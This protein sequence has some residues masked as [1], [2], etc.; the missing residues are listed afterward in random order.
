M[1]KGVLSE[2]HIAVLGLTALLA[3]CG[4]GGGG[5]TT[6]AL[7]TADCVSGVVQTSTGT[8]LP[9][10]YVTATNPQTG[11]ACAISSVPTAGDGSYVISLS[12]C[13]AGQSPVVLTAPGGVTTVVPGGSGAT[14]AGTAGSASPGASNPVP[15]GGS[16]GSSSGTSV[17][18]QTPSGT[19]S[20]AGTSSPAGTGANPG[21]PAPGTSSAGTTSSGAGTGGATGASGTSGATGSAGSD[22]GLLVNSW[23]PGQGAS[24]VNL[25]PTTTASVAAFAGQWSASYVPADS[26]GDSGTCSLIVSQLGVISATVPNCTSAK[27]GPFLLTGSINS[28]GQFGGGTSTGG[29]YTGMFTFQQSSASGTWKNGQDG[30][31]WSASKTG[32]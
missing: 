4:G 31:S 7:C 28:T 10:V 15:T 25:N 2:R 13:G 12:T 22:S 26:R 32:N 14:G 21:I 9:G 18:G 17:P 3:G 8:G 20:S 5:G 24:G 27:S 29:A 23:S 19:S 11:Q 1:E 6:A 16:S 30:G